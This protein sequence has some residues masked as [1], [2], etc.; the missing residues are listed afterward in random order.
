MVK[1]KVFI[2]IK[3]SFMILPFV[4]EAQHIGGIKLSRFGVRLLEIMVK[5]IIVGTAN[6]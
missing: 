3:Q 6:A 5:A 2:A 1:V 4:M